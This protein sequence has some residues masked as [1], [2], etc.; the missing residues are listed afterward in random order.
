[1]TRD[2]AA[3]ASAVAI[4]APNR[5]VATFKEAYTLQKESCERTDRKVRIE[6]ALSQVAGRPMRLDFVVASGGDRPEPRAP[7]KSR[8]QRMRE[9]E[10]HPRVAQAMELFDAEVLRID[11]PRDEQAP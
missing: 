4:S 10:R 7:Q 2:F 3:F 11:E 5:L 1:M 8:A 9:T 6:E